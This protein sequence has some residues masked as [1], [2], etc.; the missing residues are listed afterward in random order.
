MASGVSSA[1]GSTV[2]LGFFFAL[3]M[4]HI[5][6]LGH[7]VTPSRPAELFFGPSNGKF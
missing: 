4:T 5:E 2:V 6:Y 3:L 1:F 7:G